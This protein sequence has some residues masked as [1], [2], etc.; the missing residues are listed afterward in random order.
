MGWQEAGH[1]Q[2]RAGSP[3]K[4]PHCSIQVFAASVG[5]EPLEISRSLCWSQLRAP[6]QQNPAIASGAAVKVGG[7]DTRCQ[8]ELEMSKARLDGAWSTLR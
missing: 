8:E 6:A 2:S 1:S 3:T 4:C 7:P 5:G